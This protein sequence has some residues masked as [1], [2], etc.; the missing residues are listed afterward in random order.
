MPDDCGTAPGSFYVSYSNTSSDGN[1]SW[2]LTACMPSDQRISPWKAVRTR[3]DFSETLYLE[4]SVNGY[5]VSGWEYGQLNGGVFRITANTTAGFFE[6]PNYMNGGLAGPLL[7]GNLSDFCDIHCEAQGY[8]DG[9]IYD[10]NLTSRDT[11]A[12]ISNQ[13]ISSY[14]F[15]TVMNL[16]LI[17]I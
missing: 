10:H 7:D 15:G 16:S 12:S 14:A 17:H 13:T 1:A 6:L 3:Q 4:L 8:D 5:E 2:S 9:G 11:T